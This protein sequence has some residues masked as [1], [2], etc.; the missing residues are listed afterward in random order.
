MKQVTVAFSFT[1]CNLSGPEAKG[2]LVTRISDLLDTPYIVD[3]RVL[4][5]EG[6]NQIYITFTSFVDI[7]ESEVQELISVIETCLCSQEFKTLNDDDEE[8][9]IEFI[10][11]S[12]RVADTKNI[13]LACQQEIIS[14]IKAL[15]EVKGLDFNFVQAVTLI[16]QVMG[17]YALS[18]LL[19]NRRYLYSWYLASYPAIPG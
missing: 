3:T 8:G 1:T 19:L 14:D 15:E 12:G 5:Y 18:E 2:Y 6:A 10:P 17:R 16:A 13:I 11:S 9:S 4:Y 7:L